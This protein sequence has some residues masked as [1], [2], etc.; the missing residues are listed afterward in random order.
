MIQRNSIVSIDPDHGLKYTTPEPPPEYQPWPVDSLP[1][2][3]RSVAIEGANAMQCDPVLIVLPMLATVGAAIGNTRHLT[4]KEGWRVSA[5]LWTLFIAESGSVKTPAMKLAKEPLENIEHEACTL[6]DRLD[7]EHVEAE[8]QHQE[9]LKAWK[10]KR[11][12]E[13]PVTPEPPH[14]TR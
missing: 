8:E 4:A 14:P 3:L 2:P 5:M 9:K 7:A 13:R 11:E 10:K 12:G 1:E 6:F